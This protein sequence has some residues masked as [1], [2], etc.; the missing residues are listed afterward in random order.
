MPPCRWRDLLFRAER[1]GRECATVAGSPNYEPLDAT[2][3]DMYDVPMSQ[4]RFTWDTR[5]NHANSRKHGVRFEEAITAFR[6]E[7][8]KVYLD[9]DHSDH[10]ERFI[11]LGLSLQLRVLVVCHCYREA[12]RVVRV[13]SAR[14]ADRKEQEDYWS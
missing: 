13:I 8:A 2:G 6:D 3:D 5:K 7:N 9:P 14:K 1:T 12:E 10:E 4:L 11:L